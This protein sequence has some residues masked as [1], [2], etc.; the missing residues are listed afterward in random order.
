MTMTIGKRQDR[1]A[2]GPSNT[3]EMIYPT[4]PASVRHAPLRFRE[5]V[6]VACAL[7]A[8]VAVQ[9]WATGS[10]YLVRKNFWTDEFCTFTVLNEGGFFHAL[11]A[12]RGAVEINPPGLH[13]LLF[14]FT[15]LA[16]T[17]EAAL[18]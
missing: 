14:A 1:N 15:T 2:A 5:T 11:R 10:L 3:G 13:I 6:L 16:G 9:L 8:L 18:R 17:S 7:L 4:W 12:L